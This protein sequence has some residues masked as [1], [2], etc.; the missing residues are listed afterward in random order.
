M[1]LYKDTAHVK[2]S[3]DADFD[4]IHTPGSATPF[5]GIYRCTGCGK[6]DAS[7]QGK[8]LP[9]QSHHVHATSQP[10]IRWKLLV[11]AQHKGS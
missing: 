2:V 11:F 3:N 8:P 4:A 1:A 9:P 7:E 5:S 10:P 6:E